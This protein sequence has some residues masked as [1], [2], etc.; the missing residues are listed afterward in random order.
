MINPAA[1]AIP[2][3]FRQYKIN[4]I[5]WVHETRKNPFCRTRTLLSPRAP[6]WPSS[7]PTSPT[8]PTAA[9]WRPRRSG[10]RRVSL[11]ITE[12]MLKTHFNFPLHKK[13]KFRSCPAIRLGEEDSTTV[14]RGNARTELWYVRYIQAD[15]SM[16]IP[17]SISRKKE[18][19]FSFFFCGTQVIELCELWW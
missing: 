13:E 19:Q 11:K 4:D 15:R 18:Q 16:M 2:G 17:N 10:R 6:S 1:S 8:S 14:Q 3:T 12:N 7:P 5:G 9:W